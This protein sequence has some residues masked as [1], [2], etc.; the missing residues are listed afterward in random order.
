[1]T[2]IAIQ[3][4]KD[5]KVVDWAGAKFARSNIAKQDWAHN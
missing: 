2:N 3:E 5:G 4:R 1:M